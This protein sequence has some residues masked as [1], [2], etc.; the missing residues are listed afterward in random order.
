MPCAQLLRIAALLHE[1]SQELPKAQKRKLLGSRFQA[2]NPQHAQ[3][4][5]PAPIFTGRIDATL[6]AS[7]SCSPPVAMFSSDSEFLEDFPEHY[8]PNFQGIE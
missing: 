2:W 5:H 6:T 4:G 3:H 1:W 7:P 8:D